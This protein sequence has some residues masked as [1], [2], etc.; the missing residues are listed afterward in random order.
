MAFPILPVAAGIS[1]LG[2]IFGG[3]SANKKRREAEK[4]LEQR[5]RRLDQWYLS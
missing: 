3:I 2:S 5:Q 1:A 4:Q